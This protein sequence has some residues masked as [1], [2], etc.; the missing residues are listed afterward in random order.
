[1]GAG[2]NRDEW[3]YDFQK[4]ALAAKVQKLL[5]N[6]AHEMVRFQAEKPKEKEIDS[7]VNNA[8]DFIKWT[9]RLKR[10]L[11]AGTK[12]SYNAKLIRDCYYR[13]F[14]RQ[15][16]YFDPLLVHRRYRQHEI[17]P[18]PESELENR[19]IWL[20]TGSEWPM[21]ALMTDRLVDLMPQGGS[22]CF[23]YYYYDDHGQRH[24]DNIKDSRP[25]SVP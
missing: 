9:D 7:F 13:P 19:A 20:K 14:T 23:P 10:S 11:I 25:G 18:T 8:P 22:Q 4:N 12:L 24:N 15:Y 17:F 3:V 5:T 6:Y 21:Y 2:T 16:L 1:M